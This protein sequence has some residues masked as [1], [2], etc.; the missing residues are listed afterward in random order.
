MAAV[1]GLLSVNVWLVIEQCCCW[2]QQ[3]QLFTSKWRRTRCEVLGG[4]GGGGGGFVRCVWFFLTTRQLWYLWI[5]CEYLKGRF[6]GLIEGLIH[7]FIRAC[8][9]VYYSL[10]YPAVIDTNL[11]GCINGLHT[12]NFIRRQHFEPKPLTDVQSTQ[13]CWIS[14][15][16]RVLYKQ[17][18]AC[19]HT[20]TDSNTGYAVHMPIFVLLNPDKEDTMYRNPQEPH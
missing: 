17:Y 6:R 10:H 1:M 11:P 8:L 2:G 14:R 20:D 7:V 15:Q 3:P 9:T 4:G 18:F 16:I 19:R 5:L 12:L 13:T